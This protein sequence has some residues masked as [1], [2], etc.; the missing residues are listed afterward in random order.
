MSVK[1]S[2]MYSVSIIVSTIVSV[3][4]IISI[5]GISTNTVSHDSLYKPQSSNV[6]GTAFASSEP[7]TQSYQLSLR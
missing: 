3:C 5:T 6:V 7:S 1:Y 4:V 2:V